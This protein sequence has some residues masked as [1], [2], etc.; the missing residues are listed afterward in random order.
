MVDIN[1]LKLEQLKFAKKVLIRD[2]FSD[3][4]YIGGCDQAYVRNDIISQVVVLDAKTLEIVDKAHSRVEQV[5]HYVPT[6][7]FFR[8]GPAILE[9][10]Q[11]LRIKPDVLMIDSNGIL[12]PRR[13]GMA[14]HVGVILDIPT[15]GISKVL[16]YGIVQGEDIL[17]D[18]ELV[19]KKVITREFA[20]PLYVSP[21]HKITL[22]TS[23]DIINQCMKQPHKL[24][25]PLHLAHRLVSKMAK[26]E[27]SDGN[28]EVT[29]TPDV[30]DI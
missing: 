3:I 16:S 18:K 21:G 6:F 29:G 10:Y 5:F 14:S 7:S 22:K 15:I 8:E 19:G 30:L 23:I 2:E 13:L 27:V 20:N 24:P 12:H 17:V 9:A 26:K 11:T 1:K 28:K 4:K 25:E